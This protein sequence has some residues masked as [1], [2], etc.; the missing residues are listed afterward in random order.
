MRMKRLYSSD[1]K[2]RARDGRNPSGLRKQDAWRIFLCGLGLL[3]IALAAAASPART[4]NAGALNLPEAGPVPSYPYISG[5][6]E[7][8]REI[9]TSGTQRGN[10][11]N[12][13]SK[14]GD[15]ITLERYFLEQVGQN[16]TVLSTHVYLQEVIAFYQVERARTDNSF[17]NISLAAGSG[18]TTAAVLN[19]ANADPSCNGLSPL[20]CEY[21]TVRPTIALIMF[22]TNDMLQ[23]RSVSAFERDYRLVV[24]TTIDQGIIPVAYTIPW[25]AFGNPYYYNRAIIRTARRFNI[26]LID[27]WSAMETLPGHGIRSDGIHPSVPPHD[28]AADLSPDGL[29]Y[30]YD[31]RN[32]LSLQA[33]DTL[34]KFLMW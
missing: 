2:R 20:M 14:V 10:R 8:T 33:L 9:F 1:T 15:S 4:V 32:L 13:F 7:R 27:Y 19:P 29:V 30:G 12:V 3:I 21:V 31:V 23:R 16:L 26:P 28:N 5:I 11:Y 34:W 22:G 17:T 6:T 24:Q 25:S 18:W